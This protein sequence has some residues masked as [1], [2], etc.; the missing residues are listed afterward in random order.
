V[1]AETDREARPIATRLGSAGIAVM[2]VTHLVWDPVLTL[3][4]VAEFGLQEED[5]AVVRSLLAVHPT[6]WLGLKV[7][8]VGGL[9]WVMTREGVHRNPRLAW[10]PWLL[11]VPGFLGPL[12]WL[13]LFAG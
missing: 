8:T 7:A 2:L 6:V 9:A 10:L 5:S 1:A 12:G 11:A 3:L 4:G 13:E